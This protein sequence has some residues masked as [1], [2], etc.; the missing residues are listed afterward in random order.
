MK[1]QNKIIIFFALFLGLNNY[2]FGEEIIKIYSHTYG[3]GNSV[4]LSVVPPSGNYIMGNGESSSVFAPKET[5][6]YHYNATILS[7]SNKIIRICSG[8]FSVGSNASSIELGFSTTDC[9]VSMHTTQSKSTAEIIDDCMNEYSWS[10]EMCTGV[11]WASK[12][13]IAQ[14]KEHYK[15]ACHNK[16]AIACAE[17]AQNTNDK[18]QQFDLLLKSCDYDGGFVRYFDTDEKV[19]GCGQVVKIMADEL[20]KNG[21]SNRFKQMHNKLCSV[22]KRKEADE[23]VAICNLSR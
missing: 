7:A 9:H 16:E 17:L 23:I 5:G 18:L 15:K 10:K 19:A 6:T 11:F 2:S 4:R 13:D 22:K 21:K 20:E 14:A 12:K 8:S 1:Y 3:W